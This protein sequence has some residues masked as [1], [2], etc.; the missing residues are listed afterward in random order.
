MYRTTVAPA[1]FVR[2]S[3]SNPEKMEA[4]NLVMVE[5]FSKKFPEIRIVDSYDMTFPYHYDN[6]YSD[7]GHYGRPGNGRHYFVDFMLVHI[8]LNALCPF[9]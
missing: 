9:T 5:A 4:Y 2:G 1:G 7:G 3:P 6:N 8:L